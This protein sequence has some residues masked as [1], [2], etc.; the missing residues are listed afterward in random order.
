MAFTKRVT[1][2]CY[3]GGLLLWTATCLIS[4][5]YAYQSG[6]DQGADMVLCLLSGK[7][8]SVS[9]GKVVLP[10]EPSIDFKNPACLRAKAHEGSFL[11]GLRRK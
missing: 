9:E 2:A 5:R 8:T 4:I 11:W 10:Q 6:S 3:V 7:N 1:S